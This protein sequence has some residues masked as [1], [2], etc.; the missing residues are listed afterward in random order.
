[1]L[2]RVVVV[3][4]P[5]W[6]LLPYDVRSE[7]LLTSAV[8]AFDDITSLC[9]LDESGVFLFPARGPARYFGGE[10][11]MAQ[12]VYATMKQIFPADECGVGIGD[13]RC[14]AR[15]AA[16]HSVTTRAPVVTAHGRAPA[17]LSSLSVS[18]L[19][20]LCSI[21]AEV[22]SLFQR[23][24]LHTM[25]HVAALGEA[26]LVDRFGSVGRDVF[27]IATGG[28]VE[29]FSP[30]TSNVSVSVACDFDDATDHALSEAMN[31]SSIVVTMMHS[32]IA[33]FT[34][35]LAQHGMQC[36]RLRILCETENTESTERVWSDSRG[37]TEFSIRERLSWQLNHWLKTTS[38]DE[39]PTSFVTRI[40]LVALHCRALSSEQYSLWGI[41]SENTE[42]LLRS[43]S[44]VSFLHKD[45]SITVPRW[46]GGRDVSTHEHVA[47]SLVDL[48][49]DRSVDVMPRRD[50]EWNGV[51]PAPRPIMMVN[52]EESVDVFDASLQPVFV[53]GRH[54]L[55]GAPAR[56]VHQ[57]VSWK[58]LMCAGPWPIE[59]RWWDPHRWRRHA[60]LQVVASHNDVSTAWLLSTESRQWKIVGIYH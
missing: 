19:N 55:S 46:R 18:V 59:E 9:E 1:V 12:H 52:K 43:L 48:H 15:V 54:E 42:R 3:F 33:D 29:T 17:L 7:Q 31:D 47:V 36:L 26:A 50:A 6:N 40:V 32:Y 30:T 58:I 45:I 21:D 41:R 53:T 25:G 38:D 34:E 2:S 13:S 49:A 4:F 5:Q 51:V 16:M 22:V 20:E 56:I 23:L 10:N 11:A 44:R 39:R 8:S 37:F 24:G 14:L 57:G 35:T 27:S 28:E 60:R